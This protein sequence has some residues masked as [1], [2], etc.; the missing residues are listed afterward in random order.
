M[1]PSVTDNV[2]FKSFWTDRQLPDVLEGRVICSSKTPQTFKT[3]VTFSLV[4]ANFVQMS[5][6]CLF[7]KM[8]ILKTNQAIVGLDKRNMHLQYIL[9]ILEA[10]KTDT[11]ILFNLQTW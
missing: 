11:D 7:E 3:G 1:L 5:L 9:I 8:L 6:E 10:R 4:N 2:P